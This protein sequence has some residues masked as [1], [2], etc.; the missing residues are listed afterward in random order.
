MTQRIVQLKASGG[1]WTNYAK[2]QRNVLFYAYAR[3]FL[4]AAL[5][6]GSP[7]VRAYLL[8]HALELMFKTYL[9]TSG[10]GEKDIKKL[11]HNLGRALAQSRAAGLEQLVHISPETEK[12]LQSFNSIYSSE[13]FRY[14]SILHFLSPPRLPDL[15][16]LIRLARVLEKQLA[17]RVRTGFRPSGGKT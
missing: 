16:R 17:V 7:L 5:R 11:K 3:E 9:L 12:A 15:P 8:G 2:S 1:V 4:Q 6:T 10:F 14:F 13:A